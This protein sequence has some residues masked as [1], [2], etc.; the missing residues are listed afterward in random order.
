MSTATTISP[1]IS[2]Q[3][4]HK[5]FGTNQVLRGVSMQLN[6]GEN[7]G[8]IGKSGCGKSVLIKCIIGLVKPDA[9][10][11]SLFGEDVYQISE[12][13]LNALRL[14]VGFLFQNGALYD[15]MNVYENMVFAL[16]RH[17]RL[18][19]AEM[20]KRCEEALSSVGLSGTEQVMPADLSGGMRKRI[21]MA[22]ALMMNPQIMLYDEPTSGLD[23][24]TAKEISYLIR[25]LQVTR[26]ISSVVIT[27]DMACAEIATQRVVALID[28]INYAEGTTQQLKHSNDKKVKAFFE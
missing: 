18:T 8:I 4:V 22:R 6:I 26:N 5:T 23:P 3:Q 10:S 15:S 27:H 16:Q 19:P 17:T 20:K 24:V 7:L 21:A 12:R 13:E 2:V 1:L 14:K 9:G 28:G 25:E 11:V